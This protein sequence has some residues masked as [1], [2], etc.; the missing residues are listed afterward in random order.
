MKLKTP[1]IHASMICF[2]ATK[3]TPKNKLTPVYDTY[4][5]PV[6]ITHYFIDIQY[7]ATYTKI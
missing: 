6:M 4:L 7:N 5:T 3:L 2:K 1:K